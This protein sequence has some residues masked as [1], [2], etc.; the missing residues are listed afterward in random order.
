M[1]TLIFRSSWR[2]ENEEKWELGVLVGIVDV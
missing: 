1:R 2:I